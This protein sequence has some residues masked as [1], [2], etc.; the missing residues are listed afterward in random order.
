MKNGSLVE[1]W[2]FKGQNVAAEFTKHL[3]QSKFFTGEA[4]KSN[5][6]VVCND[7]VFHRARLQ[8]QRF[9]VVVMK[10]GCCNRDSNS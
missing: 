3:V 9:V 2:L 5:R 6:V 1:V 4:K 10:D 7:A 8:H